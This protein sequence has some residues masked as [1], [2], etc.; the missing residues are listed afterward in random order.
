MI[1]QTPNAKRRAIYFFY[2]AH[3]IADEYVFYFLERIRPYLSELLI[4]CNEPIEKE[5]L[6]RLEEVAPVLVRKNTGFDVGAYRAGMETV[7]FQTLADDDEL[8]LMNATFYGPFAELADVFCRMDA[9][10]LDF[11]GITSHAAVE[12]NPYPQNGLD[13]LPEH[14]QSYFLA[15][16]KPILS[17]SAFREYWEKMPEIKSYQDSI[18]FHESRFTM[19]FSRLG[20]RWATCT[21]TEQMESL[22]IQP[23]I[24]MPMELVRDYGCPVVKRRCFFQQYGQLLEDTDGDSGRKLLDYLRN[25][26]EYPTDYIWDNLLRTCNHALLHA[27]LQLNYILPDQFEL[28][29]ERPQQ[30]VA[31]WFHIIDQ[32]M[33]GE[34]LR[35][36]GSMPVEA[37]VWITTDTPEKKVAI[38]EAFASLSVH[39]VTVLQIINRGRWSSALLVCLAP[40]WGAYD[41]VCYAHDRAVRQSKYEIHDR[42]FSERCF[43]N[44]LASQ[45]FVR[46]I[47]HT[48]EENPRMGLLCPPPPNA[49]IYYNTI[50]ISDWGPN[51]QSTKMLYDRLHLNIPISTDEA[52][53]APFGF[54]FWFRPQALK[55]LFN[56]GWTYED[57]PPEPVQPEESVLHAVERIIPFVVQQEGYYSGWLL[58]ESYAAVELTNYHYLLRQLNLRLIP[59]CS[60]NSFSELTERMNY[61]SLSPR[62][63]SYLAV[64]QWIK[65]HFPDK[66]VALLKTIRKRFNISFDRRKRKNDCSIGIGTRRQRRVS[67]KKH[68]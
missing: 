32:E 55:L 4:V 17:S 11:W 1:I 23:A 68:T 28:S 52:P 58:S 49:S 9:Q 54:V 30:R 41:V 7:G 67:R 2:D 42:T 20:F 35:Y 12:E 65:K 10:D 48:F 8:I 27:C 33:I 29:C 6:R 51:Y 44:T 24:S 16:R 63:A 39:K 47:L 37:D 25:E 59:M 22:C 34:C 45:C 13:H 19:F 43:Q 66:F 61:L 18:S 26:T 31:L 50:G 60:S 64:T 46:N 14:I 38:Q 21:G 36:A 56:H 62:Y 40:Y 5:S 15:I 53:V 57:F 3:G